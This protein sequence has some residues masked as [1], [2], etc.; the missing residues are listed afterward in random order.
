MSGLNDRNF[1]ICHKEQ[2]CQRPYKIEG[3]LDTRTIA[4]WLA[5]SKHFPTL[6][7]TA[8]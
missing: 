7:D 5:G 8:K 3:N 4:I 2:K 1:S 6:K